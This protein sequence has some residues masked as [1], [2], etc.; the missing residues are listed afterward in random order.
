MSRDD[1]QSRI[2]CVVESADLPECVRRGVAGAPVVVDAA[3]PPVDVDGEVGDLEPTVE[4]GERVTNQSLR[5]RELDSGSARSVNSLD[6]I[7]HR[8]G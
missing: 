7:L 3:R 5:R 1:L 2:G 6:G 8:R 4:P